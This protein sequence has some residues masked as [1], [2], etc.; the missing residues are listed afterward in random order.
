MALPGALIAAILFMAAMPVWFPEGAAG[1]DHFVMPVVLFP[2]IWV[3]FFTYTCAEEN[4]P[5]ATLV[6]TICI[7]MH[8]AL[9]ASAF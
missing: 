2:L 5:R 6:I 9:I 8:L 7:G 4:L 3:C 1:I